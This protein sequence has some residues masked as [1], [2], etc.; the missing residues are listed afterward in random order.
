MT[1]GDSTYFNRPGVAV[2]TW[3]ATSHAV[4]IEWQGW[5]DSTEFAALLDAGLRA[6]IENHGSR[7]LNDSRKMKVIKQSDQDWMDQ[8]F[9]PRAQAAG[10]RRVAIVIPK[11]GLAMMNVEAV[12]A[13]IPDTQLT[14]EYFAT[15]EGARE[16]LTGPVTRIPYGSEMH[17][18]S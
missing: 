2:V 18:I 10:L 14:V 4:Y 7:W 17:P 6:L 9:F 12:A 16:W 11:S 13:R 15:V 5:A 8:K 3:D 1:R